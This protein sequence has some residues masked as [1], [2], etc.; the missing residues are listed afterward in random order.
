[1]NK[2]LRQRHG[3]PQAECEIELVVDGPEVIGGATLRKRDKAWVP[4]SVGTRLC[5]EDRAIVLR[6]NEDAIV[7]DPIPDGAVKTMEDAANYVGWFCA[8]CLERGKVT[9]YASVFSLRPHMSFHLHRERKA[10]EQRRDSERYA[11]IRLAEK[12]KAQRER[13]ALKRHMEPLYAIPR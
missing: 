11:A 4:L 12:Q 5:E 2:L 8:K 3:Q 1:M 13:Y 9:R 10:A 7:S 6:Y